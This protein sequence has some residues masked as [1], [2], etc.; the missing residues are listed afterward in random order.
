MK[1]KMEVDYIL[2]IYCLPVF[3]YMHP[4]QTALQKVHKSYTGKESI[5]LNTKYTT[6]WRCCTLDLH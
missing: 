1:K 3:F 6:R 5:E 4:L 2:M